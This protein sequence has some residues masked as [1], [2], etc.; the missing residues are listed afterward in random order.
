MQTNG[1]SFLGIFTVI[2]GINDQKFETLSI[3]M[4]EAAKSHIQ[5][6]TSFKYVINAYKD[7]ILYTPANHSIT[8]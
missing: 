2:I 6:K 4:A 1:L 3:G 5:Y 8:I 7:E